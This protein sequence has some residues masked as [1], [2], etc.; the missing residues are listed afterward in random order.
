MMIREPAVAG[1]FYAK[2]PK[3]C[4]ADV[5]ACARQA[6]QNEIVAPSADRIVGGVVP[7]AGWV[8][9]GAIAARVFAEIAARQHP[10]AIVVFGAIHVLHGPRPTIFPSGAWQ[11]PLGLAHIDDRLAGR[12]HGHTGL[13][14]V[15]P[16]AHDGEHSIEVEVP[17]IQHMLPDSLVVPI[18]VPVNDKAAAL[19]RSVGRTCRDYGVRA[20]FIC[21][22][23]LTH[24]GP[25]FGFTPQGEGAEALRWSKEVNDRR[26]IDLMLE[27][28][29]EGAVEEA[30]KYRNACGGGAIA[31]TLAACAAYGAKR[32]HLLEHTTSAEVGR[33]FSGE[34]P[35]DA[36]GYAGIV[37]D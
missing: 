9:S 15:D 10:Q 21:S 22:T 1:R 27:M 12:L 36:V 34:T 23:D 11:T 35:R 3:Q 8:Y 30:V 32:T 5:E 13:L 7:H 29:A 24:Y 20:A 26:M 14:E 25:S 28:R 2:E 16:H 31:A 4:L 18:M 33:S 19:G 37:I 6:A 17:F